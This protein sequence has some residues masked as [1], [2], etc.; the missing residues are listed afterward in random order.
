MHYNRIKNVAAF[1]LVFL[2]LAFFLSA[3]QSQSEI[4]GTPVVEA[5]LP[6]SENQPKPAVTAPS[7][8]TATPIATNST[9]STVPTVTQKTTALLLA[10]PS[11]D[12]SYRMKWPTATPVS[13]QNEVAPRTIDIVLAGLAVHVYIP[14]YNLPAPTNFQALVALHG[15]HGNGTGFSQNVIAY[16]EKYKMVVLSPTFLYNENWHDPKVLAEEDPHLAAKINELVATGQTELGLNFSPHLLLYGF[17]R[18]AQ[19]AHRYALLYPEKTLAV[20]AISGGSY[21]LPLT[22]TPEG[23][24]LQF[25]FGVHNIEVYVQ[26]KFEAN[27]FKKVGFWVEVGGDD[28][29][30]NEV[31]RNFDPYLGKN[32]LERARNFYNVLKKQGLTCEFRVRPGIG[33]AVYR[34]GLPEIFN[35]FEDEVRHSDS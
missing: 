15:M 10:T 1:L 11:A 2:T 24:S 18:G 13:S 25:P 35:F 32:R 7:Q 9:V 22:Q 21:T 30:D 3:C 26:H 20:A 4:R 19:L 14:S 6:G 33:H 23:T 16:A 5:R 28:N 34:E 17:S 12:S 27:Q 8:A 31:S 29:K